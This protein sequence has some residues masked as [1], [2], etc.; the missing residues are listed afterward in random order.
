[1]R[2]IDELDCDDVI[3]VELSHTYRRDNPG[4]LLVRRMLWVTDKG[5][6]LDGTKSKKGFPVIL[7]Y[8]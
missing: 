6:T 7:V 3:A 1:M 8:K 4:A 2:I 5:L